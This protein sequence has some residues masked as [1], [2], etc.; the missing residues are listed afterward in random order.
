[1]TKNQNR[2]AALDNGADQRPDTG[3]A[4]TGESHCEAGAGGPDSGREAHDPELDALAAMSVL[5]NKGDR[6][7]LRALLRLAVKR[8]KDEP[9]R[10]ARAYQRAFSM[11]PRLGAVKV[12]L[13]GERREQ[14]EEADKAI[15]GAARNVWREAVALP[16]GGRSDDP[17]GLYGR[18][19]EI[20]AESRRAL[21]HRPKSLPAQA[22][23]LGTAEDACLDLFWR[24]LTGGAWVPRDY[25]PKLR[26]WTLV[27]I[28]DALAHTDGPL[29]A[30]FL[31]RGLHWNVGGG[32]RYDLILGEVAEAAARLPAGPREVILLLVI[33][34]ATE[35]LKAFRASVSMEGK[36]WFS[37]IFTGSGARSLA[38]QEKEV[39]RLDWLEPLLTREKID[40]G[41]EAAR[42]L[43]G[44]GDSRREVK[45]MGCAIPP[46]RLGES[47]WSG[48]WQPQW[49]LYRSGYLAGEYDSVLCPAVAYKITST[50]CVYVVGRF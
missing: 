24:N 7:L 16:P 12:I 8:S 23:A 39:A 48:P 6:Y 35:D 9:G 17:R 33:K 27:Q 22:H 50:W 15:V 42:E 32:S 25:G 45:S 30:A 18:L 36:G 46:P 10:A 44:T 43:Y 19:S 4:I 13:G 41:L 3:E 29:A 49:N 37:R 38:A 31:V 28:G 1:M 40:A 5:G 21:S 14:A 2:R 20:D 34:R 47:A 11:V 26:A